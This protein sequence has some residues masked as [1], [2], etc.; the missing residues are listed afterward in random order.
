MS[1]T[2]ENQA[3]YCYQQLVLGLQKSKILPGDYLREQPLAEEF[4]VSRTPVREALRK[5]ES[6]GLVESEP[7]LGMRVRTL[8]YTEVIELY[9]VREVHERAVAR[10]AATKA[11]EIELFELKDVQTALENVKNSPQKMAPLNQR[12]HF[13]LLQMAKNRFLTR[14]VGTMQRTMLVLGPSTLGD[15][16]RAATA[17]KEHRALIQA[18]EKRDADKAE[19]IMSQHLQ[20]AQ[21]SR[22]RQY[23]RAPWGE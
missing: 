13:A 20:N 18:I 2:T 3:M 12:F 22:I 19:S 10:I 16:K 15:P 23:Q 14:A 21:R 1:S 6:E 8:D 5:L 9:E 4:G 11:T 17:I 7:R